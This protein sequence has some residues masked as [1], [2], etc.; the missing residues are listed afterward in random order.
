MAFVLDQDGG[1]EVL[2]ELSAAAIKGLADQVADDIGEGAQVKIYTTDRAAASVSVPAEMQAKD[3]VLTRAAAAAGLEVRPKPATETRSRGKGRKARSEASPA[4]A[5]ASGDAN[6]AWAAARR[7][8]G[9][10]GR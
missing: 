9:R 10:A 7:A 2:K 6:E 5:K 4:E 3:G 8:Q 1:A